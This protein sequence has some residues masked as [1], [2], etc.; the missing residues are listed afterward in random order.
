M[1]LAFLLE[2]VGLGPDL[3][4][5]VRQPETTREVAR[6]HEHCGRMRIG[7]PLDRNREDLVVS[8]QLDRPLGAAG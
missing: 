1:N 7:G 5:R 6:A 4:R 3:Q 2:D 8:Q